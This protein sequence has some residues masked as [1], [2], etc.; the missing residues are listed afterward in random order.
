MNHFNLP[1]IIAVWSFLKANVN[2]P[3]LCAE[4]AGNPCLL[5]IKSKVL[6]EANK[7]LNNL[8]LDRISSPTTLLLHSSCIMPAHYHLLNN[9][10]PPT[11]QNSPPSVIFAPSSLQFLPKH[12]VYESPFSLWLYV[13]SDFLY[14]ISWDN[15]IIYI[16]CLYIVTRIWVPYG[17]FCSNNLHFQD[18]EQCPTKSKS[19]HWT[20]E[21]NEQKAWAPA[22]MPMTLYITEIWGLRSL[23]RGLLKFLYSTCCQ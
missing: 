3:V 15:H 18:L 10:T 20:S 6:M 7:A 9:Q 12:H 2:T 11:A 23:S 4:S 22:K 21:R 13:L 17:Q 14:S 8:D 1:F 16:D 5:G 19:W